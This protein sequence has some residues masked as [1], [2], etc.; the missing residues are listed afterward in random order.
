[1]IIFYIMLDICDVTL[2]NVSHRGSYYMRRGKIMADYQKM[3]TSLF[4]TVTDVI[5]LLQIGQQVTE[6]IFIT[7][8]EKPRNT[9]QNDKGEKD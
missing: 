7:G 5:R 1:M 3:Y 6:E 9:E 4:N 2:Y 8:G